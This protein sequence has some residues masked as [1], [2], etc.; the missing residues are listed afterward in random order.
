MHLLR[1]AQEHA[2]HQAK[3]PNCSQPFGASKT[4]AVSTNC[5]CKWNPQMLFVG[6]YNKQVVLGKT[7]IVEMSLQKKNRG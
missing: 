5:S 6:S 1:G 7:F 4:I 2:L 3:S